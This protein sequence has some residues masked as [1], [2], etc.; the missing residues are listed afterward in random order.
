MFEII[1]LVILILSIVFHEV[2]HGYA[3]NWLGDPTAR[4]AGRLSPNPIL[5]IDPIGSVLVPGILYLTGA[6][7]LFGWAKPVPYNPYNLNNQKWGE[8]IV[9]AAG[10]LANLFLA[11]V[12]SVL[13][14]LSST[15]E[16]SAGF[17]EMAGYI[18]FINVLL[19]IFNSIP[20]PPLDGSKIIEPFLP[21]AARL[22]YHAL[23]SYMENLGFVGLFLFIFI[24]I[25]IFLTPFTKIVIGTV[26]FLTGFSVL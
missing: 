23:K 21:M 20:F 2:S 12:F 7:F 9:A 25:Q 11:I 1:T 5:H 4:L 24:F 19:A 26:K 3:A 18:V 22:K 6:H 10:P 13:I 8:A 17:I 16:L 15:L 14:R